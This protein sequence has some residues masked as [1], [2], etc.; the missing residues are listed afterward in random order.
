[1]TLNE[2]IG[3][4]ITAAMRAKDA[5]TLSALSLLKTAIVNKSV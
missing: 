3:A 1:M 4:D 5:T 2:Q